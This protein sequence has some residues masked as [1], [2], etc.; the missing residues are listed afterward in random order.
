MLIERS[1]GNLEIEHH[2]VI[3]D[4]NEFGQCTWEAKYPFSKDRK[5]KFITSS[6]RSMEFEDGLNKKASRINSIFGD[7]A[8]MALG[9]TGKLLLGWSPMVKNKVRKYGYEITSMIS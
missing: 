5:L 9:M 8:S 1:K 2:S 7:G 4:D 3:A 6:I